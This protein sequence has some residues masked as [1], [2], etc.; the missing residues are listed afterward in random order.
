MKVSKRITHLPIQL[1][2]KSTNQL[3]KPNKHCQLN[4]PNERNLP[5]VRWPD[6]RKL[7]IS[8][9]AAGLSG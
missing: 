5:D 3:N 9:D 2:F 8:P 6:V 4:K 7:T 1:L